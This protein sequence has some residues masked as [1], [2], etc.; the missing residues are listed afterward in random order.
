[1]LTVNRRFLLPAF[2]QQR[3][4]RLSG[5]K[6]T[7]LNVL[8]LSRQPWARLLCVTGILVRCSITIILLADDDQEGQL[9]D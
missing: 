7:P 6:A 8:V 9:N 5:I 1:M 2:P 4:A 3:L